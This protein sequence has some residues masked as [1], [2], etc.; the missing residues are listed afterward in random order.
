M[1]VIIQIPCL[2]EAKTLPETLK[3]IPR[4]IQGVD[5]LEILV[6][7]DGSSDDTSRVAKDHGVHHVVRM[8]YTKG[9]A[10]AFRTGIQKAL[11]LGADVVVNTDG[12]NQY[13]GRFIPQL[14]RPILEENADMVIGDRQV[15]KVAHFSPLKRALQDLGS[16]TVRR[17]SGTNVPDATSGFRALSREAA[18][19]L[20]VLSSY[21]YTLETIV[22]AGKMGLKIVSVPIESNQTK[23]PSRLFK[24]MFG[25]IWRSA[26]TLLRLFILFEPLKFFSVLSSISMAA[27]VAIGVRFLFYYFAV[28][29]EGKI[30][31]LILAAI[32]LI[33]GFNIFVIGLLSANLATNRKLLEGC[34]YRLRRMEAPPSTPPKARDSVLLEKNGG[35]STDKSPSGQGKDPSPL[36]QNPP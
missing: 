6:I 16:A 4:E 32:L 36:T 11:E 29:G 12:D 21:T 28:S 15:T 13:P 35:T 24:S 1:K 33:I 8:S 10:N 3:E 34:L 19:R 14:I 20:N 2:N 17:F 31:S 18:L 5:S 25:Y 23:R 9:L 26:V 30:Q 22:Q 27:G 7:D